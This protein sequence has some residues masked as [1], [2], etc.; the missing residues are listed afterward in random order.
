MQTHSL[1]QA[2]EEYS[3]FTVK[4]LGKFYLRKITRYMPLNAMCMAAFFFIT[5]IL[6]FGPIWPYWRQIS[7]SC[8]T[9]WWTSILWINN[10]YPA[11]YDDKRLTN[12]I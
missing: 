6:G 2:D 7:G 12:L 3:Q 5:P 9:N 8:A 1:L 10:L 11:A 4:E